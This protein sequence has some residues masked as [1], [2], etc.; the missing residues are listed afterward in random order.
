MWLFQLSQQGREGEGR[1]QVSDLRPPMF[2]TWEAGLMYL[3]AALP[4][5]VPQASAH[6]RTV[7]RRRRMDMG[8]SAIASQLVRSVV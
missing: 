1:L 5:L 7:L 2:G 4:A 6:A 8:W 3:A